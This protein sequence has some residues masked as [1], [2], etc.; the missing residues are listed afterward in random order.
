MLLTLVVTLTGVSRAQ[1]WRDELATW[2]AATRPVGDLVR[3]AGTIDAATGPYYLLMHGWI[4]LFGDSTTALR[5]PSVLAMAGAAGLTARLGERLV[6]ARVGLLAGLLFAVLPGTSRYA[7]EARPY[8]LATLLAVLATLL[9]VEALR[10]PSWARWA[11]YAAAVAGLGLTH[12]IALTLLAAHAVAVL[13]VR[14]RDPTAAGLDA[15]PGG[16]GRPID[17]RSAGGGPDDERPDS[18]RRTGERPGDERTGGARQARRRVLWRWL[19]ALAPAVLLV[20]PLVLV[21]RGQRS[22]QLDW[23]DP[24]RLTD[25]PALPGGVAQS[26]AVGGLLLG[27]AALG[28]GRLVRRALLPAA[29]VLLPVLLVFAAGLVVPLWV[30]RYLVFTVP[31]G[32][33]LAGAALAGVRLAPALAVVVLAGVLGLPD[34]AALR[35]THEWPRSATVDYR[36]V[37]RVIADHEQPGDVIVFSPRDS[38]LFLDLGTAY[39]LGSRQP[40]DV[41]VVR[42]QRQRA[43]LWAGECERPAECLAGAR[44]VWL[45]VAGRRSDPVA[46]VPGAKGAA[47][48][49]GF[50]VRQV[51]PRP[52]L[53]VALLA[54]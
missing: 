53:T 18:E 41:L 44:R 36:G 10:R 2:S 12:L 23:V 26:G 43:D 49:D 39:H 37:A 11:G 47:L 8:A 45:V 27:L 3:L 32:C 42:D 46:T 30:P 22:R 1:L 51:W 50:I 21:A 6:D 33:L 34:Q 38:W 28:A 4:A 35:R 16:A 25:L 29:C 14:W 7:Q 20:S 40:R 24:A 31:F 17:D 15:P 5:L 19:V 9:L 52:G 48:R 54:R 13:L